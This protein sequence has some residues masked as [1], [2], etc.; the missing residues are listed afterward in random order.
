M[1]QHKGVDRSEN[2]L[3][4]GGVKPRSVETIGFYNADAIT[5]GCEIKAINID[6]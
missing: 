4:N 5:A 6:R 2:S 1:R 3:D